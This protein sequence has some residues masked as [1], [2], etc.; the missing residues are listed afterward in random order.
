MHTTL[1][2][3]GGFITGLILVAIPNVRT[4]KEEKELKKRVEKNRIEKIRNRRKNSLD[5]NSKTLKKFKLESLG[6]HYNAYF[7]ND[8]AFIAFDFKYL[9]NDSQ[10]P[11]IGEKEMIKFDE[12]KLCDIYEH[13]FAEILEKGEVLIFSKAEGKLVNEIMREDKN[14]F[15]NHSNSSSSFTNKDGKIKNVNGDKIDKNMKNS[16]SK[17][18]FYDYYLPDGTL[19]FSVMNFHAIYMD[20]EQKRKN[21]IISSQGGVK[22][23]FSKFLP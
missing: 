10:L 7:D 14:M 4:E 22:K 19:F 12:S 16:P 23:W 20:L 3:L 1:I 6:K 11:K 2:F 8:E 21:S 15:I 13:R 17:P 18:Q 9:L 5:K